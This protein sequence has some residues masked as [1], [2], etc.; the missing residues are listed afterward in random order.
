[1]RYLLLLL[2]IVPAIEIGIFILFGQLIGVGTTVLFI[3]LTGLL[4][5]YLAK[6]Q[7]FETLKKAQLEM[8][9]GRLPGHA[10]I[11]G[12]CVLIGGVLILT[13]GFLTDLLGLLLLIPVT[14]APFKKALLNGI[15][16][17][18]EKG[19]FTIIR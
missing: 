5:A 16:K 18:M 13:P 10:I 12:L 9:S 19:T 2:I 1:M 8:N 14:R 11:D 7:G 3:I 6:R 17:W 4:G 15:R